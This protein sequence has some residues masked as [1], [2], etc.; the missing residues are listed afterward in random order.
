MMQE[1]QT[2]QELLVKLCMAN[3]L[4]KRATRPVYQERKED[5]D[6]AVSRV[7]KDSVYSYFVTDLRFGWLCAFLTLAAQA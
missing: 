4:H 2:S 5:D 1:A 7:R 3:R 6:Y